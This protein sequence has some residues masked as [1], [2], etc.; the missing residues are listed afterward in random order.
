MLQSLRAKYTSWSQ[1]RDERFV[2][3]WHGPVRQHP[4]RF[5]LALGVCGFGVPWAASLWLWA[6]AYEPVPQGSLVLELLLFVTP[7][8]LLVGFLLGGFIW[9]NFEFQFKR[10]CREIPTGEFAP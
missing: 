6:L 4:W 5:C 10:L 9:W 2:R 7:L 8:L 3:W 1:H